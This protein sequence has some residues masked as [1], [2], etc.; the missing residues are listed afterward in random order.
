[1]KRITVSIPV[2]VLLAG[3][4]AAG[5]ITVPAAY[6][7]AAPV[8]RAVVPTEQDIE[9]PPAPLDD[10]RVRDF[11]NQSYRA[12]V[13]VLISGASPVT[14]VLGPRKYNPSRIRLDPGEYDI[15]VRWSVPTLRIRPGQ[16]AVWEML[17]GGEQ[18][19]RV[20]VSPHSRS[21]VIYLAEP[22]Y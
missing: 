1:M 17:S 3:C 5:D 22:A 11:F 10:P 7:A 4:A 9:I 18:K 21:E 15:R 14:F 13:E 6:P 12:T 8:A 2:V 19:F 20:R 16:P